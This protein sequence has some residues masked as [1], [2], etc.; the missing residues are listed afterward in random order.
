MTH[1]SFESLF[2][3]VSFC[4]SSP[5]SPTYTQNIT[6]KK[7]PSTKILSVYRALL[8]KEPYIVYT[9]KISPADILAD[10]YTQNIILHSRCHVHYVQTARRRLKFFFLSRFFPFCL[11]FFL[12]RFSSSLSFS[13]SFSHCISLPLLLPLSLSLSLHLQYVLMRVDP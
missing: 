8:S 12:S 3:R 1:G 4:F 2:D 7:K 6:C 11:A 5:K 10:L 13:F 9:L